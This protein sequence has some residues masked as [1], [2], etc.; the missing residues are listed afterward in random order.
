MMR[1][2]EGAFGSTTL[3]N[4]IRQYIATKSGSVATT[5]DLI[6]II[7]NEMNNSSLKL[8]ATVEQILGTWINNPGYPSIKIS[9]QY[10]DSGIVT[11][12]QKRAVNDVD[13][14]GNEIW[15]Q[16]YIP[17]TFSTRDALNFN[18]TVPMLWL[19]PN[20][21][22]TTNVT[23]AIK[24]PVASSSWII[25]NNQE[26]GFYRVDYDRTNWN[27]LLNTLKRENFGSIPVLNRAQMIDDAFHLAES[28]DRSFNLLFDLLR[29]LTN[30]SDF[31][32]WRAASRVLGQLELRLGGSDQHKLLE[33]F[34]QNVTSNV[35][36]MVPVT[37]NE[38]NHG[39]RLLRRDVTKLA[40][41]AGLQACV[42]EVK[43]VFQQVVCVVILLFFPV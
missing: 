31:V 12:K 43:A 22:N 21:A 37:R 33:V 28:S 27:L 17:V 1:M 19:T 30:E 42:T 39:L 36:G 25:V 34:I 9:R 13:R 4:I 14:T 29:Y 23:Y 5:S 26:S 6:H 16:Y 10:G 11:I 2:F 8:P 38:T 3:K 24:P 32:V 40:C 41:R 15:P 7:Q 18:D 35:Y 20:L